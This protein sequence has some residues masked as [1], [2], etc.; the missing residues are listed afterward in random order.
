[1]GNA[2]GVLQRKIGDFASKDI[3]NEELAAK[4]LKHYKGKMSSNVKK[5]GKCF[6]ESVWKSVSVKSENMKVWQ[7]EF[8]KALQEKDEQQCRKETLG[9]WW[10]FFKEKMQLWKNLS[11][12][13]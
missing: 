6:S 11:I 1:M 10:T 5:V 4:V 7:S 3:T 12:V 9:I 8:A 13:S 2:S